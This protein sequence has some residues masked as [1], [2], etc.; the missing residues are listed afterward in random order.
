M[1]ETV[2]TP[3]IDKLLQLLINEAKLFKGVHGEITNLKDELDIIQS[4]LKD[5]DS[6]S[7]RGDM[8]SAVKIWMKQ[9]RELADRIEDA[10]DEYLHPPSVAIINVASLASSAK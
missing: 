7:K 1:A 5:A 10:I 2:L 4:F 3:I 8:D 9:V 6:R